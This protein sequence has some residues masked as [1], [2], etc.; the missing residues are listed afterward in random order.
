VFAVSLCFVATALLP[1]DVRADVDATLVSITVTDN[2]APSETSSR[3]LVSVKTLV[4][5][6]SDRVVCLIPSIGTMFYT[7]YYDGSDDSQRW[8]WGRGGPTSAGRTFDDFDLST[9]VLPPQSEKMLEMAGSVIP[10]PPRGPGVMRFRYCCMNFG[11][12][13][14]NYRGIPIYTN[15]I[16]AS[17]SVSVTNE[18]RLH[19]IIKPVSE[20]KKR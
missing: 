15:W 5:N 6:K 13:E 9:V 14:G 20:E 7:I 17:C 19:W 2:G 8:G 18:D 11:S 3:Y 12:R 4:S 16:T 10:P 1:A